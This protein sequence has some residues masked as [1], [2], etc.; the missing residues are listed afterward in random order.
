VLVRDPVAEEIAIVVQGTTSDDRALAPSRHTLRLL[1]AEADDDG[2]GLSNLEEFEQGTDWLAA[3]SDGDGVRDARDNCPSIANPDQEDTTPPTASG[4][5]ASPRRRRGAGR[6]SAGRCPLAG[7]PI[8]LPFHVTDTAFDPVRPYVYVSDKAGKKVDFVNLTT[9]V[10]DREFTFNLMPESLALTPDGSRLFVALLTREHSCCWWDE[11]GHEGYIA[12]FDWDRR[13]RTGTS[14]S[15][16]IPPACWRPT[17]GSSS[18][19]R[20]RVSGR[21]SGCSTPSRAR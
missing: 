6:R 16:K 18:S 9:G 17:T 7:P 5:C 1:A 19:R 20:V 4:M 11:D 13:C 3:D 10:V 2:D 21:T 14:T 15:P 8:S 12:S